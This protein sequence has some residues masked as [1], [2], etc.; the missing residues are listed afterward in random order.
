MRT[1]SDK[2]KMSSK[3]IA[4]RIRKMKN[5]IP[6]LKDFEM[7]FSKFPPKELHSMDDLQKMLPNTVS[8]KDLTLLY[9]GI[10]EDAV[11][12]A[13]EKK[14]LEQKHKAEIEREKDE[15]KN[16]RSEETILEG[17]PDMEKSVNERSMKDFNSTFMGT[18]SEFERLK[19]DLAKNNMGVKIIKKY[20][21]G[22]IDFYLQ[23]KNPRFVKKIQK[24][25]EK[26]YDASLSTVPE[27]V[28]IVEKKIA[29]LEKKSEKSGIPY[30]ILKQVYNRG[31][32]AWRTGHRPGTTPQQ[33]AFAR[34]NSFIT[35]GKTRTTADK[36]LWS[37]ASAAKKKKKKK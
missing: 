7:V 6:T 9:K 18:K 22:Q 16:I 25:I 8:S 10:G 1:G 14:D 28:Q 5:K 15:I 4:K 12:R 31:M 27:S 37:K 33:W 29:G 34:V 2:M 23:A 21:D 17:E 32:A 36:D 19:K 20:S 3:Q 30:G 13:R 11:S 24:D 26:R 35:G